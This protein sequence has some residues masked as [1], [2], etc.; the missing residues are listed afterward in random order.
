MMTV[1]DEAIACAWKPL[2]MLVH[3]HVLNSFPALK[4]SL[5]PIKKLLY[6]S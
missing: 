6:M 1:S 5:S 3:V 4:L 2:Q